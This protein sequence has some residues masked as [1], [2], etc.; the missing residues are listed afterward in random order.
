MK[1]QR[2]KAKDGLDADPMKE[3]RERYERAVEADRDNRDLAREDL[4][5]VT[6]PGEQWDQAQRKARKGRPC[7]EFPIL[8]SH[9]RQVVNDQKKARPQIKVR[10]L[11]DATTKDADLRQGLIRNIESHSNADWV[12]DGAFEL[13]TAAGMYAWRVE[14]RYSEDDALGSGLGRGVDS[15][16]AGFGLDGPGLQERPTARTPCG[17]S[18]RR[19]SAARSSSAAIRRPMPSILRACRATRAMARGSATTCVSP[20]TGARCR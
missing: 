7:Y 16:P 18:S 13:L 2:K 9:W 15:G 6:I 4:K 11:K 14:T 8:R 3:M 19:R 17:G 20:S 10:A 12:Y 5:F 1:E